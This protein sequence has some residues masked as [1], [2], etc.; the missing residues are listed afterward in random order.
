MLEP[1]YRNESA[2]YERLTNGAPLSVLVAAGLFI[3]YRLLPVLELVAVAMLVALVLRTIV[4]GMERARM[5]TWMA[6]TALLIGLGAFVALLWLVVI[7][8]VVQEARLLTAALPT[9][10]NA[11]A[12]LTDKIGLVPDRSELA[13]RLRD[14]FSRLAGT[15]PSLATSLATLTGAIV[16][17]LF[18]ALYMSVD[19]GPLISGALRLVPRERRARAREVLRLIGIRLRGWIVGTT[20]VS[21][22]IG[23]GG[24]LGLWILGAPLP[25][26]FGLLAGVLNVVPYLGS[27]VGALLPALLALTISPIKALS[28]IVLFVILNQVEGNLLQPLVMGREVQ[29]HPALVIF[30]FLIMGAL[31]GMVGLLLAVPAAVVVKTLVEELSSD[32]FVQEK[33]KE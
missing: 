8:H 19:P 3:L 10:A 22:F 24:G 29:L 7:P 2:W 26:A 31:L 27:T 12:D 21:L 18:M 17:V 28:V 25:I 6:G 9:Y 23:G 30:S 13:G 14:L 32:G 16:A 33:R 4:S 20:I 15:L 1:E 11:L 5:P